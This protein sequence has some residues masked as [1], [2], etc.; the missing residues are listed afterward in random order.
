MRVLLASATA[1]DGEITRSLLAAEG[2]DCVPCANLVELALE[3]EKGVGAI[4]MT[5]EAILGPGVGALLLALERQPGWSDIPIVLLMQ[6]ERSG[7][8]PIRAQQFLRNLTLLE[9]PAPMRSVVSAVQAAVRG[10]V[11]QYLIRDQIETI[12]QGEAR[13]Q[14]MANFIPHLAW[15]A[16]PDGWIFWYN[17]RWY[18]YTGTTPEQMEGWGWRQVHDP[19]C[20]DAVLAQWRESLAT[21]CPFDMTFPIKGAHDEF[22]Q[23]WTRV[24]PFKDEQDRIELW[25]GTHTDIT[26]QLRMVAERD[27]LLQSER[28][29]RAEAE[30]AGRLK[31]EFLATL[32]HELRTPLTAILGWSQILRRLDIPDEELN[33]G[34]RIIERN[35]RMQARL[36][37]ELLDMSRIVSGKLKLDVARVIVEE[38]VN[39]AIESAMP[40]AEAKEIRLKKVIGALHAPVWGDAARLQQVFSNLLSNAIKFT[41]RGGQVHVAVRRIESHVEVSVSDTG[42][43]IPPEFLPH[44]FDRFRQADASMT[45]KHGGL[46]LGLAIVKNLVELH[47]GRVEAANSPEGGAT[48][49]VELP[50]MAMRERDSRSERPMDF[51]NMGEFHGSDDALA[52]VSVL[53]VDDQEDARNLVARVLMECKADVMTAASAA[54]AKEI[55]I[56]K[57]PNVLISDIGMPHQDGYDFIREVRC[58]PP[59]QGGRTPAAALTAFARSEDRTRALLAG[60]QSHISKPVEPSELIAVVASLAGK[61]GNGK[62]H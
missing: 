39:G 12:R 37:E 56:E 3:M 18:D 27:A 46:G 32:S 24:I 22:R 40:A 51:A 60:Y 55:L 25:F 35:S 19:R 1:R 2:L 11:R 43:G 34:L 30:L 36:I 57:H 26:D 13:F 47:G 38:I 31:D 17:Q 44:V 9:R 50:I 29:A 6:P 61:S 59:G 62:H 21:G 14:A 20:I 10:R 7:A 4:L 49:I 15:M 23:F 48:F 54:E 28:S 53:V 45:R 42:A 8:A 16:R 33:E 58:L 52:G 41:P 5:D